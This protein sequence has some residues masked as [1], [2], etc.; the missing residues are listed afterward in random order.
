[1]KKTIFLMALCLVGLFSFIQAPSLEAKHH[2]RRTSVQLSLGARAEERSYNEGYMVRRYA[3]PYVAVPP[4]VYIPQEV[5]VPAPRPVMY[6][7]V[8]V[9]PA[10]AYI[11]ED[12]YVQPARRCVRP[13]LFAGL[14][15]AWNLR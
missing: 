9:Y 12:I 7:P 6:Q 1:M 13:S 2:H 5:Y 10:P 14:S 4:P 15:F 8:Y 3:V 11:A